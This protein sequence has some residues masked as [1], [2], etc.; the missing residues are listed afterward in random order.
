MVLLEEDFS[1]IRLLT[2]TPAISDDKPLAL[3]IVF[4]LRDVLPFEV[5]R[6]CAMPHACI[7]HDQHIVSQ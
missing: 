5:L 4:K 1:S 6:F 7:G 2:K 3:P